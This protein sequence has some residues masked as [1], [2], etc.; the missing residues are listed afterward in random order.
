[1][2]FA[3]PDLGRT[4]PSVPAGSASTIPVGITARSPG[5]MVTG[6]AGRDRG[7]EVEAGGKRTLVRRQRQIRAV[8]Q[9][10]DPDLERRHREPLASTAAI[11]ATSARATSSFDCDGQDSTPWAVTTC[12]LL[13]SPPMMPV[14]GDTSLATIQSHPL[15]VELL[16]GIGDDVLGLGGKPDHQLRPL[17]VLRWATV[18]RMS[19]FSTS[20]SAGVAPLAFL[21]FSRPQLGGAPVRDG[22]GEDRAVGRQRCF[23]R[24]QHLAR[25]LDLHHPHAR[26]I[27]QIDRPRDQHRLGARGCGCGGDGVALLAGGTVGDVA[28]RIDRLVGRAGGHQHA[29]ALERLF[30]PAAEQALRPQRRS[31]AA[32]PCGRCRLR[33]FPPFRRHSARRATPSAASCATLR[34]VAAMAPHA[35]IHRGRDQ[36]R[37]VGREQHGGGKVI[38]MAARHLRHQIGGRRRDDDH[39]RFARQ[40]DVADSNSLAGSNRSVNTRSPL[41]APAASGVTNSCA[42]AVRMQ[43]TEAP[44]S[45]SRRMRS[46]DL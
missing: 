15:R 5:A 13:R 33:R 14:A 29:L 34:R 37:P 16:L 24:G 25:G 45:L 19:G 9:A 3:R 46:S 31:R 20:A 17:A 6:C 2:R 23:D 22:G 30:A 18:A 12:T 40:P 26:R 11:R 41:S 21:I 32:P 35:R 39:I 7:K 8:R 44:R 4:W 1:M 28:H 10:H 38:G 36:H 43:R 27:G 42:A